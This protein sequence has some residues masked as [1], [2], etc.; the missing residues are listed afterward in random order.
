MS[1]E[2][3]SRWRLLTDLNFTL[4]DDEAAAETL[5]KAFDFRLDDF[6]P[7]PSKF[8]D[9]RVPAQPER[10]QDPLADFLPSTSQNPFLTTPLRLKHFSRLSPSVLRVLLRSPSLRSSSLC[11]DSLDGAPESNELS[12]RF[13]SPL[14][15]P[16]WQWR[17]NNPTRANP[18]SDLQSRQPSL[19][20]TPPPTG[21]IPFSTELPSPDPKLCDVDDLSFPSRDVPNAV[22]SIFRTTDP[23]SLVSASAVRNFQRVIDEMKG[24]DYGQDATGTDDQISFL[25][26]S[27]D[28]PS[29]AERSFALESDS[30]VSMPFVNGPTLT[31]ERTLGTLEDEFVTLLQQ[32]AIEEEVDAKELR[33]FADRL[34]RMAKGRR[35]LAARISERKN[36]LGLES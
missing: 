22:H 17:P 34:E 10:T 26:L 36:N 12:S 14:T 13:E 21:R 15:L 6:D 31:M 29:P 32:R 1:S 33:A 7:R 19:P 20:L 8:D 27:S 24:V 28:P 9:I 3:D 5:L 11:D 2:L 18:N 23:N 16:Q 25:L 35:H 4:D 30:H